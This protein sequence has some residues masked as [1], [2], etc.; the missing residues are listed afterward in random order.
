MPK[1]Q[2]SWKPGFS[3][4][5]KPVRKSTA[6]RT[7]RGALGNAD[8]PQ[9]FVFIAEHP[10][11]NHGA[12]HSSSVT[13][14]THSGAPVE[15]IT[16]YQANSDPNGINLSLANHSKNKSILLCQTNVELIPKLKLSKKPDLLLRRHSGP[17]VINRR[18]GAVN[19]LTWR[20]FMERPNLARTRAT[21]KTDVYP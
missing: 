14:F 4:S 1:T 20:Q 18:S 19:L 8:G 15:P 5:R 10:V 11:R 6:R 3:L 12:R 9:Q 7:N 13:T 2:L 17:W 16:N 21:A